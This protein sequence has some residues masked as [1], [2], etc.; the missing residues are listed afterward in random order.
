MSVKLNYLNLTPM[1]LARLDGGP[2]LLL[3]SSIVT[4]VATLLL[5]AV[6]YSVRL[7][8][9]ASSCGSPNLAS[10][11]SFVTSSDLWSSED[12]AVWSLSLKMYCRVEAPNDM[13]ESRKVI[14]KLIF[15]VKE[16]INQL[17]L[18]VFTKE[19]LYMT[20]NLQ[21]YLKVKTTEMNKLKMK[22]GTNLRNI[23]NT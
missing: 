5:C 6:L 21:F 3:F 1:N 23:K 19:R 11:V 20:T 18:I 22:N 10:P 17:L 8:R 13:T 12:T 15:M 2:S 9:A 14:Y 7:S 16:C 4:V